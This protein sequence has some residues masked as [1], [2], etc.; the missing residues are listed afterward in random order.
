VFP[1]RRV[2]PY[3]IAQLAGAIFAWL[4]LLAFGGPVNNLGATSVDTQRITYAGAFMFE[5]V[6]TCFLCSVVLHTAGRS[7]SRL[8]PAAI[9]MTIT[10]CILGFGVVTGGSIRAGP[11]DRSRLPPLARWCVPDR[12]RGAA[13]SSHMILFGSDASRGWHGHERVGL[14]PEPAVHSAGEDRTYQLGCDIARLIS[15][16][17]RREWQRIAFR[18]PSC[19]SRAVTVVSVN[20]STFGLAVLRST[21]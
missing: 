10:L 11:P 16:P 20:T 4:L 14:F 5:A 15:S 13:T 9:G 3:L 12:L 21:K 2:V 17:D 18:T 19:P 6:G 1:S 8:A 7:P